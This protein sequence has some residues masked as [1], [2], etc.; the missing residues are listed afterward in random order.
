MFVRFGSFSTTAFDS[1]SAEQMVGRWIKFKESSEDSPNVG[2]FRKIESVFYPQEN[3][4]TDH[5]RGACFLSF[6]NYWP[7][8]VFAG[9]WVELYE[10]ENQYEID[11]WPCIGAT[12]DNDIDSSF[13]AE[14]D[15][16]AVN[17]PK[18]S[19]EINTGD[20]D[21]NKIAINALLFK[22]ELTTVLGYKII[23][24]PS[25]DLCKSSTLSIWKNTVDTTYHLYNKF[26]D[27][28][29]LDHNPNDS[30]L[31]SDY[32]TPGLLPGVYD[33]YYNTSFGRSI[34]FKGPEHTRFNDK[35]VIFA[36]VF[37]LPEIDESE[38]Y[39]AMYLGVKMNCNEIDKTVL[40][41]VKIMT[42][43]FY[44]GKVKH[45]L[46]G[47]DNS[48]IVGTAGGVTGTMTI[49]DTIPDFAYIQ[50][51]DDAN[52]HFYLKPSDNG[53][54]YFPVYTGVDSLEIGVESLSAYKAIE[55]C[56]LVVPVT[57]NS[58]S[59]ANPPT[60]GISEI[61]LILEKEI[62]IAEGIFV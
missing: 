1:T 62:D 10:I 52:K 43:A 18:Y 55:E 28:L 36:Y 30:P 11:T 37:K 14:L 16:E 25:F 27:G 23:S 49:L 54:G 41:G 59:R 53:L 31:L 3:Q 47:G 2:L 48:D 5:W 15:G 24:I 39:S 4:D 56:L 57:I 35:V 19:V 26:A 6:D 40:G 7:S 45:I 32:Y 38:K 50:N 20:S 33:L 9:G 42:R 44:E 22:D 29:Y 51:K 60:V 21:N 61:C 17:I 58:Y 12:P 34:Q 13:Y 8:G 46:G